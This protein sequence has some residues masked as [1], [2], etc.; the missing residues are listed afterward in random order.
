M[1]GFVMSR[2]DCFA[3]VIESSLP[4]WRAQ[5]WQ[6]DDFPAFGSL[7]AIRAADRLLFGLVYDIRTGSA[8]PHRTTFAYQKTEEELKREQPQIFQFLRTTFCCL[9][10]GYLEDNRVLYQLAPE[11]PKIHTFIAHATRSQ[12]LQFFS[13]E[14]YLH[15]LFSS[16]HQVGSLDELLLSLL[17]QLSDLELVTQV[18]LDKFIE[19]FSLLTANDYRRLKLFLQRARCII[20]MRS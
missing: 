12:L 6:W 4:M 11:P 17:K 14:Q 16:A 7:V 13:N 8:D 5:S 1:H 20:K 10:I 15:L 19:T 18:L 9:S 2:A 3:E